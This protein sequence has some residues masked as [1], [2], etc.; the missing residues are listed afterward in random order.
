MTASPL[1]L[2]PSMKA[3]TLIKF[4]YCLTVIVAFKQ[5]SGAVPLPSS[6]MESPLKRGQLT[7][8][9]RGVKSVSKG[10][11]TINSK[12]RIV[13]L[14]SLNTLNKK[15]S[16]NPVFLIPLFDC[17]WHWHREM[18]QWGSEMWAVQIISYK[19]NVV[20]LV[21]NHGGSFLHGPWSFLECTPVF[22]RFLLLW[23]IMYIFP[24][25]TE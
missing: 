6:I 10:A 2:D 1:I 16:S 12:G 14:S 17:E 21:S 24:L 4:M 18:V 23:F 3:C 11:A 7:G 22:R 20:L 13:P 8:D 25:W 9:K 19:I 15:S 5:F